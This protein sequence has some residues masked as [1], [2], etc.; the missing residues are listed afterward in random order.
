MNFQEMLLEMLLEGKIEDTLARHPTIPDDVKQDYLSKIPNQNAQHLDWVLS[1]HT[2]G[3]ITSSHDINSTLN[4]FNKVKDKLPKK[5]IHQYDS[6][7]ELH[8]AITPHQDIR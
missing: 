8:A 3:N 7:D 1:Q 4:T 2:K 5:Q 6:I